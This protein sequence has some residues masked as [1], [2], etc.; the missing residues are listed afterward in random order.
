VLRLYIE[1][2]MWPK[3]HE[4]GSQAPDMV[5]VPRMAFDYALL[6]TVPTVI[7]L[8]VFSDQKDKTVQVLDKRPDVQRLKKQ[9]GDIV[10]LIKQSTEPENKVIAELMKKGVRREER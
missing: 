10:R 1:G 7:A 6:F 9:Q 4:R 5:K 3:E 2:F 8:M